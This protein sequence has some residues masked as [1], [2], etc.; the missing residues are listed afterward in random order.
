MNI[1]NVVRREINRF[2]VNECNML[3]EYRNPTDAETVRVCKDMLQQLHDKIVS[4]GTSK[5]EVT[6]EV[7]LNIIGE[8]NHLEQMMSM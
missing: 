7:M 6:V 1:S 5:H 3:K 2:L 8:L 4:N